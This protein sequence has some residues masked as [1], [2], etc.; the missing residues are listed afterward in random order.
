VLLVDD[1]EALRGLARAVLARQ[2]CRVLE[3]EDGEKALEAYRGEP[4]GVDLVVLDLTMP[5]LSGADTLRRLV[6]LDPR[7][8][9]LLCSGYAEGQAADLACPQV[10]GFLPKP[11]RPADLLRA[12]AE[13]LGR[14]SSPPRPAAP[15]P[16]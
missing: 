11:Y 1:E 14:R 3:A 9:V 10:K 5:R 7:A 12:A 13:A 2:G 15:S 4:G 8:R 6:A 16:A